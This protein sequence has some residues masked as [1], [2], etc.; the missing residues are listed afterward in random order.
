MTSARW[1][2]LLFV[3]MVAGVLFATRPLT[4]RLDPETLFRH[5]DKLAHVLYFATL[6]LLAR[7]G[8]LASGWALALALLGYGVSIEVAQQ[9]APTR[10]AASLTDIAA[11][12]VG[13][14]VGWWLA[15][16]FPSL[17]GQP[18]KHRR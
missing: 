10:R 6:W 9:L 4:S 8:G 13:I 12:A 7:R 11:D 14:A 1:R 17:V 2:T 16:R 5:S 3:V 15:G 18:Q